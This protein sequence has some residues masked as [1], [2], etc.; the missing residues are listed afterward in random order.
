MP[1]KRNGPPDT[2]KELREEGSA[3][4]VPGQPDPVDVE[5]TWVP[6]TDP[7]LPKDPAAAVRA[8]ER[9]AKAK[10]DAVEAA[11]KQ[12]LHRVAIR[13]ERALVHAAAKQ[14]AERDYTSLRKMCPDAQ[15]YLLFKLWRTGDPDARRAAW[16]LL[17][18]FKAHRSRKLRRLRR[19]RGQKVRGQRKA[20]LPRS[21]R[22][23]RPG[24]PSV[25]ERDARIA[26]L[27]D[28]AIVQRRA[29]GAPE[30]DIRKQAAIFVRHRLEA[31]NP[32]KKFP[33][34]KQLVEIYGK[35][36]ARLRETRAE[37]E[38]DLAAVFKTKKEK[39]EE[40]V[41]VVTKPPKHRRNKRVAKTVFD[42]PV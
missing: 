35:H 14:E 34:V 41:V 8:M 42:P 4:E 32:G 9:R 17:Q 22:S 29:K 3:R 11:Q 20:P 28:R 21:P 18:I 40:V 37:D 6:A 23:R 16:G 2:P 39:E 27:M 12:A 25:A 36:E 30:K 7:P 19:L 38:A 33:K 15:A 26:F 24:R 5:R 31:N 10:M 1:R 13:T